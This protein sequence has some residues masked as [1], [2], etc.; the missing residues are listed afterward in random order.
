MAWNWIFLLAL[1]LLPILI[2]ITKINGPKSPDHLPPNP[3]KLPILGNLH[4]LGSLP[5]QSLWRLSEK[6]GHVMQFHFGRIRAVIISSPEAAK[7]VMKVNDLATC[8]RPA[9][10]GTRR[11]TYDYLDVAFS[12]YADNWRFMRKMIILELFS[13]KRV[14]SFRFVREEELTQ[15]LE[16][17]FN[18]NFILFHQQVNLTEKLYD[19]T[20]NITFRMSFGFNYRGTEFDKD[21]FHE[22][23]H[24]AEAVM[25]SISAQQTLPRGIGWIVDKWT[26]HHKR[27]ER[28]FGELDGFFSHVIEEHVKRGS[29]EKADEDKDVI[30]VLLGVEMEE[31]R[32]GRESRFTKDNI[33]A[34]LLNLFLGGIDTSALTVN[35]A[36]ARLIANPNLMKKAQQEVRNIIGDKRRV[37]EDDIENL[38]YMKL[39]VKETLR[40]HP[41]APLLLPRES[42]SAVKICGYD[43]PA[44]TLI[45]VNAW[46]IGRDPRHWKDA[47]KF[48][49]ERFEE[50][51]LDY[52]GQSFEYLPFGSGRRICPGINVGIVTVEIALA[53]LLYWFDWELPDEMKGGD[54]SMDEQSGVS[55]TVSKKDPLLV[56]PVNW[57]E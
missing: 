49:P 15:F 31:S 16:N 1:L 3:P 6:H 27:I 52:K 44:K 48:V 23:V 13:L 35:W 22:V 45:Y 20:A 34:V 8:S 37:T 50:R 28:V 21:R 40:L 54:L 53:N 5:H 42:M 26:G 29:W 32:L 39:I 41:P 18:I 12:P 57:V 55:L 51:S 17:K 10:D 47:D 4:Q 36:M 14:R 46:G 56:V 33:K 25:G 7:E 2:L 11:L 38:Q 9:L 19:L 30:D 43:V 24:Q